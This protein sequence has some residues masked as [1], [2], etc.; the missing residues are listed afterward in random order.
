MKTF[1]FLTLLSVCALGLSTTLTFAVDGINDN[2]H[3][4]L[5]RHYETMAI[6]AKMH[7]QENKA[8]LEDY[9]AHPYYY[10]RQGQ[11]IRSHTTANIR[12][13][14]KQLKENLYNVELHKSIANEQYS[15][16]NNAK[17][18]LENNSITVR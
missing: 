11:D 5:I 17:T 18:N 4:A 16:I 12:E 6:E 3:S 1:K 9:E 10:G 13:Y 2:D 7:L 8:L 15:P 14:E